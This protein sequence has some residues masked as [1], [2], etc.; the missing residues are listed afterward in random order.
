[1][2]EAARL[3]VRQALDLPRHRRPIV[4]VQI[5]RLGPDVLTA[6]EPEEETVP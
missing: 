4:E 3:A 1:V 6:L 5:T 2:R